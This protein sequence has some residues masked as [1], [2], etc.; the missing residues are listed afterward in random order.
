[1]IK[2]KDTKYKVY[3]DMR[4]NY[5]NLVVFSIYRTK[6]LSEIWTCTFKTHKFPHKSGY[7]GFN[8][9]NNIG[10]DIAYLYN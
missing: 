5:L 3:T 2:S 6:R 7:N 9:K 1:M 10:I 4:E 8:P